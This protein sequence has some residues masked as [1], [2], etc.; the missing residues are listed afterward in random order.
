MKTFAQ[1]AKTGNQTKSSPFFTKGKSQQASTPFFTKS[2]HSISLFRQS[3]DLNLQEVAQLQRMIGN[4]AVQRLL[5]A[6]AAQHETTSY[7]SN[8]LSNGFNRRI[9]P[10]SDSNASKP[11]LGIQPKLTIGQPGDKYEQEADKMADKVVSERSRA[12]LVQPKC[13]ACTE[14]EMLQKNAED[15][16]L[17]EEEVVR[18]KPIFE[19]NEEEIPNPGRPTLQTSSDLE[20]RL[21]TTKGKGSP[22]P[23][24]TLSLMDSSF[25]SD[26]SSVR[27][28]KDSGAVQMNQELGSHAFTHGNDIYFNSGKYSPAS[29]EGKR[30]IAHE[31]THVIQQNGASTSL[32]TLN[33]TKQ[34]QRQPWED[35][36]PGGI[37]SYADRAGALGN[38]RRLQERYPNREYRIRE[39]NGSWVIQSRAAGSGSSS[40]QRRRAP[41]VPPRG[42]WV[43]V[44]LRRVGRRAGGR[45]LVR[46][47]NGTRRLNS[48]NASGGRSGHTTPI[49]R[50]FRV[51]YRDRD[52][53]SSLYGTCVRQDRT[54]RHRRRVRGG[55]QACRRGERY[56]GADMAF[57]QRFAPQIGF[58]RGS[59]QVLSH[60]CIHLRG[61]DARTL[62]GRISRGTRVIVCAGRACRWYINGILRAREAAQER[63]RRGGR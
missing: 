16:S 3:E 28:H 19:S 18:R 31:L 52:H 56:I 11:N 51:N 40:S 37:T 10:R 2:N 54:G 50:N 12:N 55:R 9:R 53:R 61:S 24:N 47:Y 8:H 26:F 22:L 23:R 21:K 13:K 36:T 43:L 29:T 33:S 58:H 44:S 7:P 39:R 5:Q 34:I 46:V 63:R 4:K 42:R 14:Q 30:L 20:S 57:Y 6:N 62:W 60:G 17:M 25:G 15:G 27:I 59:P 35:V 49:G 41:F 45:G 32:S 38:M 48:F 1:K